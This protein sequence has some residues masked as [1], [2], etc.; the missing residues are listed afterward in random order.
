MKNI[1]KV[2]YIFAAVFFIWAAVDFYHYSS[3]GQNLVSYYKDESIIFQLV[4]D[5]LFQ[6]I[7]KAAIGGIILFFGWRRGRKNGGRLTSLTAVA[8]GTTAAVFAVWIL[9]MYC[10]TSVTAEFA[11]YR[12]KEANTTRASDI[13][14]GRLY[15]YDYQ[16][17]SANYKESKLWEVV[18][19]GEM[20]TLTST[21]YGDEYFVPRDSVGYSF[22]A[23]AVYDKDGNCIENSW[24]DFIYFN[25]IT[26]EEW[27]EGIV[28]SGNS[29]RAFFKRDKL[30]EEGKE[31]LNKNSSAIEMRTARFTGYFDGTEFTPVK[32]EYIDGNEFRTALFNYEKT[33]YIPKDIIEDYSLEWIT[34]YEDREA[35]NMDEEPI[36]L[37]SMQVYTHTYEP[38]PSFEYRGKKYENI[39]QLVEELGAELAGG[40]DEGTAVLRRY[41]GLDLIL[42]SVTFRVTCNGETMTT[43]YYYGEKTFEYPSELEFYIVSAVWCS[44]WRTA[45]L[46]LK[47]IYI[48][49]FAVA[50]I[51]A[52][53]LCVSIRNGLIKPIKAVNH[54]MEN[55][56]NR[57]D[58]GILKYF[59]W[60]ETV[61]LKDNLMGCFNQIRAL[62]NEKTRLETALTY[63]KEAEQNR[64]ALTSNIAHELKTPLAVIHGYAEG[65][66][67]KIA[68][69]K[70]EK[71]LDIILEE[72]EYIDDMVLEMLDLSRLE[73]GRVKL[74]RDE[75]SV[76][77]MAVSIF[78]K[79]SQKADERKL[80]AEI[81]FKN[82][83][84]VTADEAR[85]GQAVTN[86]ISNAIKYADEGSV[87]KIKGEKI[88]AKTM[89][90]VWNS[91]EALSPENL[92]KVWDSFYRV[93]KDRKKEGTGLGLAITKSIIELHGGKCFVRNIT[94]GV[95]FGFELP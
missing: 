4:E 20:N 57:I 19:A 38:S 10:V 71:Y 85:I 25:Y 47:N 78:E 87:I 2:Y 42:P 73:A 9:C 51:S 65:L 11:A 77:N 43:P 34:A 82:P 13:A 70:R 1:P 29:A 94:G 15:N 72:S 61:R 69:D 80:T 32:I 26:E 30:T 36:T 44:P 12:Y 7:V 89:F 91:C 6:G 53:A 22:S 95:E 66:K 24:N 8:V 48:F 79:L 39:A 55:G 52:F 40:I 60:D 41:E 5:K 84:L 74:E 3:I 68:E 54:G 83:C 45:F 33:E 37:Y 23:T 63:A 93:E 50:V 67:E 58:E 27:N 62:K 31:V 92:S 21:T 64:R 46:E 59:S 18:S 88:G 81:S 76:E 17:D 86:F 75:F 28:L 14:A 56:E 90:S 16:S 35:E 49:T